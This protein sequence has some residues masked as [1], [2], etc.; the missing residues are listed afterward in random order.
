MDARR[1]GGHDVVPFHKF[2]ALVRDQVKKIRDSGSD[3]V[4]FKVTE[5]NGKIALSAK[6]TKGKGPKGK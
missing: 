3:E 4:A 5:K 6:G 1:T 2:A